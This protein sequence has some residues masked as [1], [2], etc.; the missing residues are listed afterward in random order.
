[1][2][3]IYLFSLLLSCIF[4]DFHYRLLIVKRLCLS[5][6]THSFNNRLSCLLTT[7]GVTR[8]IIEVDDDI[9]S[10]GSDDSI[11]T[12]DG[13][14]QKPRQLFCIVLQLLFGVAEMMRNTISK[15]PLG[16]LHFDRHASTNSLFRLLMAAMEDDSHALL[17]R[18]YYVGKLA[19]QL[20]D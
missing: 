11:A 18:H 10:I 17:V 16:S 9:S 14:L 4:Q 12:I 13:G 19:H 15:R 8:P 20:L 3:G 6:L 5:Q 2:F 7:T 1:M